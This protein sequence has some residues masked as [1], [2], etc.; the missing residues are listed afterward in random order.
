MHCV[1]CRE[2]RMAE[3]ERGVSHLLS[4]GASGEKCYGCKWFSPQCQGRNRV[5]RRRWPVAA[6]IAVPLTSRSSG[7]DD[8][9]RLKFKFGGAPLNSNV[10]FIMT[11]RK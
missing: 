2:Q 7:R 6:S 1:P 4:E 9:M 10:I 5:H 3:H 8:G 11:G